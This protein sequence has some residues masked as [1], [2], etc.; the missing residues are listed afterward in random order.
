MSVPEGT[1]TQD[2]ELYIVL[3]VYCNIEILERFRN[4]DLSQ[5][6]SSRGGV[7]E[8]A[9]R[10]RT[11]A[12]PRALTLYREILRTLEV[13]P[14]VRRRAVYEEIQQEFRQ[15]MH[16]SEPAK[17]AKMLEEAEAGLQSLRQQCG[18]NTESNEINYAYDEALRRAEDRRQ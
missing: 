13:W 8:V 10:P 15:N 6:S 17:R 7:C 5:L 9:W 4:P 2:R 12:R 18:L 3:H 14:S 16:E 11:M 1:D